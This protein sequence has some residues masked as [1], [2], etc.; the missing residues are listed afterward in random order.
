MKTSHKGIVLFLASMIVST[1]FFM[2]IFNSPR[3]IIIE[4]K[5]FDLV[6][7]S[8]PSGYFEFTFNPID[9]NNI[10]IVLNQ[11]LFNSQ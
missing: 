9:G 3:E 4:S 2:G 7:T 11:K 5:G 10:E 6:M 1:I 8:Q